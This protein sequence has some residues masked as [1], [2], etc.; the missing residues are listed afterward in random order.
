[1]LA[2][3]AYSRN[4]AYSCIRTTLPPLIVN[5]RP[6]KP[7]PQPTPPPQPKRSE[8]EYAYLDRSVTEI[9]RA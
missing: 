3:A 5:G 9:R 2:G 8:P 4:A 7:R 6:N 1:L